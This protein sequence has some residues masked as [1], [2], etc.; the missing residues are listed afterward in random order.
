MRAAGQSID[1][2][3]ADGGGTANRFLMQFQSDLL[4][5]PVEVAAIQETTALGAAFLAGLAV[6]VWKAPD[7]LRERRAIAARY[8]PTMSRDQREKLYDGWKRAVERSRG[9]SAP[10]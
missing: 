2:L 5:V 9:W 3:R 7:Q 8:E 4:G 10:A 1:V 6:G